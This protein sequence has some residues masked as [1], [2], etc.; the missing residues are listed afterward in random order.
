[1]KQD[2]KHI[3]ELLICDSAGKI[4]VGDDFVTPALNK[5]HLLSIQTYLCDSSTNRGVR[6]PALVA[7]LLK[8]V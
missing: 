6:D 1:V 7:N 3:V 5:R 8:Q 2:H 4:V